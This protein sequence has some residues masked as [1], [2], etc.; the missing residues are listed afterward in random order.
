VYEGCC[1]VEEID[2]FLEPYGLERVETSW[3][4]ITW[5]DAFYVRKV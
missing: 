3:E 5:G 2:T 4:G 1:M